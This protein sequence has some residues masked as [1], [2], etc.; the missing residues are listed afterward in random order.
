MVNSCWTA[1]YPAQVSMSGCVLSPASAPSAW[2]RCCSPDALA[3]GPCIRG[4]PRAR[5]RAATPTPSSAVASAQPTAKP[6]LRPSRSTKPAVLVARPQPGWTPVS[7]TATGV[8]VDT[9]LV[10]LADGLSVLIFRF[11]AGQV[12][13][14]LHAGSQDPGPLPVPGG[15]VVTGAERAQLL[16]AFNGGFLLR[17]GVGGYLQDGHLVSV[18]RTGLASLV[19]DSTDAARV[20]VWGQRVP[21]PGSHAVSVRQNLPPLV[22]DSQPSPRVNDIGAWGATLGGIPNVARSALGQDAQGNLLFAG[23]MAILPSDLAG[24]LVQAGAVVAMELDINPEWVQLDYARTPGGPLATG[25]P[26]QHRPAI[27][28]LQG[29]TRDFV[30]VL[31]RHAP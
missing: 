25:V 12:S 28:Y 20:G 15:P 6:S 23:S 3:R 30:T 27:Q 2:P 8:A 11:R 14:A 5:T 22:Y 31:A 16:A 10:A 9:R 21:V 19:I 29:W 7:T 4:R 1:L 26:G 24:A 18:L 17:A 13:F